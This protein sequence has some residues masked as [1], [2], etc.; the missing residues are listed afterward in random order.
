MKAF[1][2]RLDPALRWRDTQLRIEQEAAA[3]IATRIVTLQS[4]L[5]AKH[6]ELRSGSAEL[7]NAGAAAFE[8]WNAYVTRSKV[9]IR[10]IN[11]QILEARRALVVQTQKITEAR[12]K[13]RVIENLK[14]SAHTQWTKELARETE[15]F[16]GEA[17]LAGIARDQA[18]DHR[19]EASAARATIEKRTGA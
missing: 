19:R 5:N 13:L 8:S 10:T 17:F 1:Q 14:D 3:R 9:R 15:A 2:F 18:R 6:A 16:A 7:V 11:A 4:E 12:R